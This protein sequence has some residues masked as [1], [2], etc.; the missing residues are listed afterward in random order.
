MRKAYLLLIVSA[1]LSFANG[2]KA[3]CTAAFTYVATADTVDFTDASTASFGTI[4][5]WGWSFGDGGVSTTQNPSHVY[6]ACGIYDVSLTIFTSA[7]CSNTFNTTV[8]VSGGITPSYTYT[9]DTTSGDVTFQPQPLGLNLNYIWA[10]GDGTY[11]S[12]TAPNH[13]YPAGNYYV[14]LTVYDAD[15][16]CTATACDSV[17][18]YIAP[19]TCSTT[20]SYNDNGSGNISFTP[21]PLDFAMTYNWDYGDGTTGTGA[22]V[23]HTYPTAGTY[24]PCLTA[25]DS[26]TMCTSVFCDTI[27]LVADPTACNFTF[28]YFD[29]NGQVGFSATPLTSNTYSWDFG[30]GQTATGAVISNTYAASGTY[31]ACATITDAFNGCTNTYC[32]SVTVSITGIEENNAAAFLLSAYP[33]P[34]HEQLTIGYTLNESSVV[35]IEL[36]DLI[37]NK[38]LALTGSEDPGRHVR[39]LNTDKLSEGAYMIKLSTGKGNTSKLVIKN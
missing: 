24:Y 11:D 6:T 30:D 18:V 28:T 27:V 8:T 7:F 1:L 17:S 29:N 31:Y 23:F 33:N 20:F 12:T 35:T 19:A 4:V 10:F 3:Q 37:G 32:D 22:F 21:S 2:S 9:V 25:V 38:I 15:S 39:I 5:S 16:I 36:F 34:A 26:S 13:T 14:C